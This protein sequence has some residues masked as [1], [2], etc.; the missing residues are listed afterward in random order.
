LHRTFK[1]ISFRQQDPFALLILEVDGLQ[2]LIVTVGSFNPCL[3]LFGGF[4]C[5]RH[6]T[7][8]VLPQSVDVRPSYQRTHF[9]VADKQQTGSFYDL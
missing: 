3:H 9:A 7:Q 8:V 5:L 2:W 4:S 1:G 6:W